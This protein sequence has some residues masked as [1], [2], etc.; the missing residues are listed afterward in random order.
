VSVDDK[1]LLSSQVTVLLLSWFE[2]VATATAAAAWPVTSSGEAAV[3][4]DHI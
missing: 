2:G 3:R 4:S 1:Q